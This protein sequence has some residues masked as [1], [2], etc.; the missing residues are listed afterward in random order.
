MMND[1]STKELMKIFNVSERQIQRLVR[2]GI[3][4]PENPGERP[5]HFDLTTVV[6]QY[7]SFLE[8]R[9]A[10]IADIGT[11]APDSA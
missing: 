2:A 10:G 3:I 11:W 6:P 8:C 1:V 9:A 5:F 7:I 4:E